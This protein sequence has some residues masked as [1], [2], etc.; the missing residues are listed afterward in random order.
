[1]K[2]IF[3]VM[4]SRDVVIVHL[5]RQG[6][7]L[8]GKKTRP[9]Q[10]G[11]GGPAVKRCLLVRLGLSCLPKNAIELNILIKEA[12]KCC[13]MTEVLLKSAPSTELST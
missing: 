5:L 10:E 1:V 8:G 6:T 3:E 9:W 12:N 13:G 4:C 2:P 11:H 7:P